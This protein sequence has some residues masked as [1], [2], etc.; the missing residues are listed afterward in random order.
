[1]NIQRRRFAAPIA[2]LTAAGLALT[3]CS[4]GD[5]DTADTTIAPTTAAPAA[6]EAPATTAPET[7]APA[8][9]EAPVTTAPD[10]LRMPLTGEPIEDASEIPDRP[11]LAVKIP[12]NPVQARPQAGLN[13]ADIIFET[14]IN[15][16]YTRL[17]AV[18]HS[19]GT[20]ENPVGPIRSGRGQDVSILAMLN[21]PL[22]AWSGG[23]A[24]VTRQFADADAA[25][26]LVN[27]NAVRGYS[28]L[29]FRRSGRGGSPHNLFSTTDT[30]WS[31]APDD[32]EPPTPVFPYIEP[33]EEIEGV[34]ATSIELDF[35]NIDVRWEYDP[36]IGKYR[37][38]QDGTEHGT[39]DDGQVLADNV[40]V[41]LMDYGVSRFDGNPE[42]QAFGSNP[43]FV[44]AG[45]QV[46][47]GVWLRF[48]PEDG[49]SLFDN[50]DDLN[51]IGLVPGRTW[52][53][54]PRNQAGRV[55][56]DGTEVTLPGTT[57]P[58]TTAPAP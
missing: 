56:V 23:N 40:V 9:T 34:E 16:G 52:V 26:T 49:Y 42:M 18:F 6:T 21:R 33:G 27:L 51:P 10:I 32:A 14:V 55:S 57:I 29:Y 35:D 31:A 41:M 25:G 3:A 4:G 30:L 53:E 2:A 17:I 37:R 58:A 45:G 43:V 1:M 12:T 48:G 54:M 50:V 24:T 28:D 8:T 20:G 13:K 22:M 38:W 36:E 39:E 19:N 15:D 5:D 44:F 7:T 11:A 47:E 46:R